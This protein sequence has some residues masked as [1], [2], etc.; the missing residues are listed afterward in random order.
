MTRKKRILVISES[1]FL[2]TGFSTYNN[3]LLNGLFASDK[4]EIAEFGSYGHAT[5]PRR[6]T[7]P[8]KQY[9]CMP[10]NEQERQIYMTP[11]SH[12]DDKG[13]LINQFGAWK[14]DEVVL[15][16]QPDFVVCTPPDEL[17][18]TESGY[19]EI[20]DIKEGEKV[21]TH[22]G[23]FMP[24]KRVM[25]RQH[26]GYLN[27]IYFNGMKHPL[28]LTDEHPVL[29]YRKRSQ[30]NQKKSIA[31]IYSG[32]EPEFINASD[33]KEGDLVVLPSFT[34]G[35]ETKYC[36]PSDY[37][38][39]FV[40]NNN[41]DR[42]SP[43]NGKKADHDIPSLVEVTPDF[44]RLLGYIISDG[45][46]DNRGVK[47]FFS[48]DEEC[49]ADDAVDIFNSLDLDAKWGY[50]K[51]K[52]MI[53]VQ[54]NSVLLAEWLSVWMTKDIKNDKITIPSEIW[55]SPK[56]VREQLLSG[57][58][59]GD[60]CYKNRTI[61]FATISKKLAY[62]VRMLYA[63][64]QIPC[65]LVS[66]P[67]RTITYNDKESILSQL[68]EVNVQ[69]LEYVR[70][71]HAFINKKKQIIGD[72]EVN[73]SPARVQ[74]VNNHIVASVRRNRKLDYKGQVYN[75]EVAEDNSYVLQS[76]AHNCNRDHWMDQWI[77]RS[78]YRGCFKWLW[79]PTVDSC[80]VAGTP[81]IT[82][83]GIKNIEDIHH[84]ESVLTKDGT[85]QKVTRTFT[86]KNDKRIVRICANNSAIPIKMTEDHPI[87]LI[88]NRGQK[89]TH[90]S[91]LHRS[92]NHRYSDAEFLNAKDIKA[93]DYV[94]FPNIQSNTDIDTIDLADYS[95]NRLSGMKYRTIAERPYLWE[96]KNSPKLRRDIPLNDDVLKFFG[97][98]IAEGS[99]NSSNNEISIAMNGETEQEHL[100]FLE[101]IL[102]EYF[103]L[104]SRRQKHKTDK[105]E[106]IR[107]SGW[108]FASVL[109]N[110]FGAG[111]H[112]KRI[113][114]FV[115]NLP[116]EKIISLLKGMFIGD[117]SDTHTSHDKRVLS[118]ST[119]SRALAYQTF[120]L[121]LKVG[122]LSSVSFSTNMHGHSSYSIDVLN[123]HGRRL[124]ELFGWNSSQYEFSDF[125]NSKSW[126][127]EETGHAIMRV[128]STEILDD[129]ID[130]VYNFEVENNHTYVAGFAVHNCPQDEEW[131][132]TYEGC[133]YVMSYTDFGIDTLA[134]NSSVLGKQGSRL[135][136][137]PLRTP[138][139][140][141]TFRPMTA[142]KEELKR[143][144]LAAKSSTPVIVGNQIFGDR[145]EDRGI[146]LSTMRNQAR[147]LFPDLIDAF[148]K[149]K[150]KYRGNA[151]VDKAILWLHTSYPDNAQS[152]D[153]PKHIER[154]SKGY[155]GMENKCHD[156]LHF[157]YNTFMC[158]V[159]K[160]IF[161]AP[162]IH[163]AGKPIE[164]VN[165]NKV[166]N[167]K[168]AKCARNT[169]SCPN[170]HGG[171][172]RDILAQIYNCAD[173]YV[174]LSIAEGEGIPPIEAKAC[175]VPVLALDYSALSEKVKIPEYPYIDKA[176]YSVHL[177]G[178]PI[179]V[180]RWYYEPETSQKRALPDVDD[181]AEKMQ[182]LLCNDELREQMGVD[183]R[184]CILENYTEKEMVQRWMFVLD[185]IDQPN[186]EN[187]WDLPQTPTK[188]GM[189]PPPPGMNA[190]MF[191]DWCYQY[192][193]KRAVDENGKQFWLAT[194]QQGKNNVEG[195]YKFFI[196]QG[197]QE[198]EIAKRLDDAQKR[199]RGEVVE[200]DQQK[201]DGVQAMII[202]S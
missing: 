198:Y 9:F 98:Y 76:V 115:M 110:L 150:N 144:W 129:K 4:Y 179:K 49:F 138:I 146:I 22:K 195:I 39:N 131:I 202:K 152:Y 169:A 136:K 20:C 5:D 58:I 106:E 15:D 23:R 143:E 174:Q 31:E 155:Y 38:K 118:Y 156:L 40:L 120:Q 182:E 57:L 126:I 130:T 34:F 108:I 67:E 167:I 166:I 62:N 52:D 125:D 111:A 163:L 12:P 77:K 196:E 42:I 132:K 185:N 148:A 26:E 63:S 64:L 165:G 54:C 199:F 170:T 60:G 124:S 83:E 61:S 123:K 145:I 149:M 21:L 46:I 190:S 25:H 90:T 157:I 16:F 14:F 82:T 141:D 105:S 119:V 68:Y 86:N 55:M 48:G 175:G 66:N 188:P 103:N 69:T 113:P 180:D 153:Y 176:C 160:H 135:H 121:L 100:H 6:Y 172:S 33:V 18:M 193:L 183:A 37:V 27:G 70:R 116:P 102:K 79:M 186:R 47:I 140:V 75:L 84:G 181:C 43:S 74:V 133:D 94:V 50:A 109:N 127:D 122:V 44:A 85:W 161:V 32:V 154:I 45:H 201:K 159:C 53:R 197:M 189:D 1:S 81:I 200:D 164:I 151:R 114:S 80:F 89:F 187:G 192:V 134:R 59:R 2:A 24:V 10:T 117:G 11:S 65:T 92:V 147:K 3:R 30:T 88:K 97:L 99:V 29:V 137:I 36:S 8:W 104:N 95:I 162:A 101:S 72:Q 71:V 73:K 96:R 17:V 142:D 87:L 194:L 93:G 191:L 107:L 28:R 139:D 168:C 35:T 128:K 112:N 171:V 177:G 158:N 91:R 13:Q 51:D 7:L 56:D 178:M 78:P 19:K 173:L 184:R 41:G